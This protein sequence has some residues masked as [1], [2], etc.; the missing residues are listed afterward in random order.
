MQNT[1][2]SVRLDKWLWAA[3]FFKTRSLATDSVNGGKVHLHDKRVKASRAIKIG[4]E[5]RIQKEDQIWTVMV[6]GLN[7]KRGSATIAQTLYQETEQSVA[8]RETMRSQKRD[9]FMKNPAPR[10]HPDKQA[11]RKIIRFTRKQSSD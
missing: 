7:D 8:D 11:R 3:R 2:E 4:D 6:T 5:L 10:K 1:L 9:Y